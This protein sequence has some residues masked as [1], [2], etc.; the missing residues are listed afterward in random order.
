[1]KK[2]FIVALTVLVAHTSLSL[3]QGLGEGA[4]KATKHHDT[5]SPELMLKEKNKSVPMLKEGG[6]PKPTA[7]AAGIAIGDPGDKSSKDTPK[8]PKK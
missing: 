3:A 2:L 8:K 1:M 4:Q 6:A 7:G 5:S